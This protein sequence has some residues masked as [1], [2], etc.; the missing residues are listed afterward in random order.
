MNGN[1]I[2]VLKG[3]P[4]IGLSVFVVG[5]W[6]AYEIGGK[7]VTNDFGTIEFAAL[8]IVGVVVAI[9]ILKDWRSGFYLFLV[10][11]LFED[12]VRK[13]L[14]NNMAIYFAKDVLV[15]LVYISFFAEVR[16]GREK[17]FH[18]PFILFLMVFVWLGVVQIFNPNSPHI[19]YGLLGFKVYFYYIPLM[20]VSFSLIRNDEDLKKFLTVNLLLAGIISI[21][22]I[23]QAILGHS[24]LNPTTLAPEIRDLGELDRV[25][26]LTNQILSLPTAVFVSS[27]RYAMYLV[28]AVISA[29]GTA[30]Y[31]L[32]SSGR[33]RTIVFTVI[34]LLGGGVIF[35]G[36]RSA[37]VYGG[38]SIVVL[39]AGFLWG[40]PWKWRQAHRM[41]KAIRSAAIMAAIGFALI[42]LLFPDEIAPRMAFYT[43]T[44]NPYS[45][46]SELGNRS[47]DYPIQ[48]LMGVFEGPN[49]VLGNGIGTASLGRQYVALVLHQQQPEVWVEEG[50]GVLI[51]EMGIVAPFLWILWTCAVVYTSWRE[52]K[53]LRQ[54]RFFPIAFAIFWYTFLLL[55]LFTYGGLSTYQNFVSNMYL[56]I[57]LGIL[58]KLPQIQN[59]TPSYFE[60][61]TYRQ[62]RRGG[63]QF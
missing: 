59:T 63:F 15:G 57:Y 30:G 11:I 54:T 60:L 19:L 41:I 24:F 14:G 51:G 13:Y 55:I 21:I 25:S 47:W 40:A 1:N 61:P 22:G 6:I 8:G 34:A 62:R 23:I 52:V 46:A 33:N 2:S 32:L 39:I 28:V 38:A 18:P 42:F 49:W 35:S 48:N 37:V 44:L 36:S 7:I 43:E 45:S 27:G 3:Q 12:L 16:R 9:F 31:L 53:R 56:W 58:F 10:W 50:Y 26:P 20:Y 29:F 5:L 17:L 4:I